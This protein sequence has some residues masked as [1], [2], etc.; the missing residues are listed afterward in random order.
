MCGIAALVDSVHEIEWPDLSLWAAPAIGVDTPESCNLTES[1]F[2]KLL[3]AL[4]R[5]GPDL[6]DREEF[7]VSNGTS[8]S[9]LG[10]VLSLRGQT[11]TRQPAKDC[12]DLL[13]FNGEIYDINQEDVESDTTKLLRQF[14]KFSGDG[15]E[16]LRYLDGLRGPWSIIYWH[17]ASQRLYFGKDVLGR[18]SLLVDT[19]EKNQLSIASVVPDVQ[20]NGFVEL[21]P[22]GLFFVD[23][24]SYPCSIGLAARSKTLLRNASGEHADASSV[25]F[26]PERWLRSIPRGPVSSVDMSIELSARLFISVFQASIERRLVLDSRTLEGN[27]PRFAVLFSGGIDSLFLALMLD[28]CM[29][30][31]EG[32]DVINVAF[33]RNE[34]IVQ[35]PDRVNAVQGLRELQSLMTTDRPLRMINVN[36]SP[37]VADHALENNVR[38]LTFPCRHLMDASI[39]T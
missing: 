23:P 22:A 30:S 10:C 37:D 33:G 9:M 19:I 35:C 1:G 25:S 27:S 24:L 5:R 7:K 13:L 6:Q 16:M 2:D 18:R 28:K 29:D 32:L 11:P 34:E 12:D 17:A 26:L 15:Y 39:G 21:P 4:S 31:T 3:P 20:C 14:K 38:P 8:I 36:V